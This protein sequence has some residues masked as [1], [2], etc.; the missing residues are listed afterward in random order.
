MK[1]RV[2]IALFSLIILAEN[3]L[4]EA[5]PPANPVIGSTWIEPSIGMDL[6]WIPSGCFFMGND[7]SGKTLSRNEQPRHKVCVNGY[8][9]GKFEVTQMQYER[10]G[11]AN[12]SRFKAPENPVDSVSYDDISNLINKLNKDRKSK[13]RLPSEAEWEYACTAGGTD[14][15]Y[16]GSGQL[17]QLAW[18]AKNSDQHTHTVGQ[19]QPNSW[20]L[21]DMSG[22]VWEWVEDEYWGDY[23][24]APQ[25]GSARHIKLHSQ[26][27]EYFVL[28]GG[29]WSSE[30]ENIRARVRGYID[31]KNRNEYHG[32]RLVY[33]EHLNQ[34]MIDTSSLNIKMVKISGKNYEIGNY[35]VTQGEWKLVM[36]TNPSFFKQCGD[37]CPVENVSW[38]DV[39]KFLRRL[40]EM[41][42][43]QYRLPTESEWT[44]ACRGNIPTKYCGSND[45]NAVAW[46]LKNNTRTTHS[47]GLKQPNG[48]GLYDMDGNV[49]EWVQD[50]WDEENY[51]WKV[52]RGLYSYADIS[53]DSR[54]SLPP[55][56][57]SDFIGFRVARTLP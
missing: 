10:M 12:P 46:Y 54:K 3:A 27:D 34:S 21:Y 16:C 25:D 8:W 39:Q 53:S 42:G 30:T 13:Y 17:D 49:S 48:F 47:V 40:N 32:F 9:L 41:T 6:V 29:S 57:W 50:D 26:P 4:A 36:G 24:E 19:K 5:F 28:R 56:Q 1:Q 14:E 37:N 20:G 45:V 23:A 51:Y 43:K 31:S 38:Y 33:D 11:G 52:V 22:N 44:Y 35:E 2:A 18:Y 15:E 55:E 7:Y